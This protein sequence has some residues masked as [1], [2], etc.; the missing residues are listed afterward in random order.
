MDTPLHIPPD[1]DAVDN[2]VP[3]E[4]EPFPLAD[5]PSAYWVGRVG[6]TGMATGG[7]ACHMLFEFEAPSY[8]VPRLEQ[9]LQLVVNR[10]KMLRCVITDDGMNQVLRSVPQYRIAVTDLSS[11]SDADAEAARNDAWEAMHHRVFDSSVWPL[12]EVRVLVGPRCSWMMTDFDHLTVDLR[13]MF[14]VFEEWQT[15]YAGRGDTLPAVP[16]F[17]YRQAVERMMAQRDTPRYARDKEYWFNRIESLPSA[18]ELPVKNDLATIATPTFRRLEQY[19]VAAC[20]LVG[21]PVPTRCLTSPSPPSPP[22]TSA[23]SC[24]AKTGSVSSRWRV[25]SG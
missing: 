1:A 22:S 7:T 24:L 21:L 4:F 19:V 9:S 11:A 16:R 2:G 8:D 10:H 25:S 20:S 17:T 5:L 15:I 3:A 14:I 23:V 6:S 13:S 12:F 18:P